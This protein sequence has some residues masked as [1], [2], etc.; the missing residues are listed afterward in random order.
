MRDGLSYRQVEDVPLHPQ[1]SGVVDLVGNLF[2]GKQQFTPV[3][4]RAGMLTTLWFAVNNTMFTSIPRTT[5]SQ[6]MRAYLDTDIAKSEGLIEP[7]DPNF[8]LV[9]HD[10]KG[11]TAPACA[12]CHVVLDPASYPFTK[13]NG[14]SFTVPGDQEVDIGAVFDE[15][16]DAGLN[17]PGFIPQFLIEA[18]INRS[19]TLVPGIYK[20]RRMEILGEMNES[21][22][23]GLEN[24]P[25]Q[26][27][28][29]GQ[30]V[31]NLVEWA[32]VAANSDQFARAVVKDY[33]QEVVRLDYDGTHADEFESLWKA[34]KTTD[35]Y[36]VRKML[37]RLI[38]T[39]AYGAP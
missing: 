13:Y 24:T 23:P 18:F 30:K 34:L 33:W 6:A 14:L 27:F 9:D 7:E 38:L 4:R 26:G 15:D 21:S 5:A 37:H 25:E 35:S 29:F 16:S 17:I 28:L 3:N 31:D 10:N 22:E 2:D 12:F 8:Q 1:A 39:E 36:S 19:K 32:S 20:E 11:I